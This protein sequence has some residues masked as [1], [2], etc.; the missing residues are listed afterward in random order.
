MYDIYIND[1]GGFFMNSTQIPLGPLH[2]NAYVLW[3]DDR[4]AIIVDPGGDGQR[5][6]K[7]LESERLKPL[8]IL[9]THAHFDNIGAVDDVREKYGC[10]VYMHEKESDWLL[11]PHKNGS[12][13]YG[14]PIKAKTRAEELIETER[15]LD[16]GPFSFDVFETPGH[17][18]GS[19]SYYMKDAGIVFSGD[20][21]FAQGIGRT[22]LLGG[23]QEQLFKSIHEKLLELPEETII[24]CGH[25]ETTTV[26]RVVDE[27]PY[28]SGF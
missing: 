18:P 7:W 26:G 4:E 14:V 23:S 8:A 15:K 10:P 25:G 19:L 1:F 2:T 6:I 3:N 12:A 27:N 20:V 9:L 5:L 16:I 13:R 17:S 21:L 22:D 11:D 28:L 24:A